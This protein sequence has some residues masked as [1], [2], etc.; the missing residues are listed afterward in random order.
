MSAADQGTR[1]PFEVAVWKGNHV[2]ALRSRIYAELAA[3][4]RYPSSEA[5]AGRIA[6]GSAERIL[7]ELIG[8]LP[9]NAV[10]AGRSRPGHPGTG[11]DGLDVLHCSLFEPAA[12]KARVSLY[13][14][15]HGNHTREV[16][17]EDLFRCY[18][19]FGLEFEDAGLKEAP[20]H[21]VIELE[22]M[23]YLTFL[24]ASNPE[25]SRG[26]V[27]GQGDFL[28]RHLAAWAPGLCLSIE[29]HA[30]DSV[31]HGLAAILRDFLS[32]DRDHLQS[33]THELRR[34]P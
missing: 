20:D 17:W 9:G 13:E 22:F 11:S 8:Q 30:G 16:L 4:F 14:R 21:M 7:L 32:A 6:D 18:S 19:H 25:T 27:L 24:E 34:L 12:G 23:H 10:V 3:A 1:T 31:Y 29:Q 5:A 15:D 26:A 2:A 28:E 33:K